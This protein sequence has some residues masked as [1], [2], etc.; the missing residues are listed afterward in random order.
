MRLPALLILL[1]L[2]VAGAFAATVM[3]RTP[4]GGRVA[5]TWPATSHGIPQGHVYTGVSGEPV[6]VNPYTTVEAAARGLVLAY[7][8]DTLLDRDP[9]TGALRPSLCERFELAADGG[10]CTFTLRDGVVFSDGTP[11]SM[12]DVMFGYEL[13]C[14]GHVEL[15]FP[16]Q[17][18]QRIGR[19]EVHDA[20]RFTV[21]FADRHFAALALVGEAWVVG[22]RAF[23]VAE[24]RRRLDVGESLPSVESP[25]FAELFDQIDS[26][27]G[28]GTG[29]YVLHND[30]DGE[31][32]WRRGSELVLVR[33][34]GSWH[35]KVR[36]GTWN[37]GGIR[38]S[39]QVAGASN[40]LLRHEVDWFGGSQLSALLAANP[41]LQQHYRLLRYAYPR[42]GAFRI[43]W[44]CRRGP[45]Q[46]A[47]VRRALAQ[48]VDRDQLVKVFD[49]AARPA[50]AH[51]N[52]GSPGCPELNHGPADPEAA[53][54]GLREAGF[55][56]ER[57][58]LH[59]KLVAVSGTPELRR[60][61]ELFAD[62][63]RRAGIELELH[64]VGPEQ[65]LE[66]KEAGDW[67]GL[68]ELRYF[69]SVGDPSVYLHSAG[70]CNWGGFVDARCDELCEAAQEESSAQ[71]R[72]ELWR[73]LHA[74]AHELQPVTLLVYPMVSLLLNRDIREMEPG[75]LGL[76]PY[77]AWVP[78]ELQRR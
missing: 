49:G 27:C 11:L 72:H 9:A 41:D 67:D 14:A 47:R 63:A 57:G 59:L 39:F 26:C 3:W 31:C 38:T 33:H 48:L 40:A 43:V 17:A 13:H 1:A 68:L 23:F 19:I 77:R 45:C 52:H 55:D 32:N 69:D 18:F 51:A 62:A 64:P 24:V 5:V 66:A 54:A 75:P 10:S 78:T 21:W 15:G 28:P 12:D 70:S 20:R 53:Q 60:M 8:H 35:R 25:R 16:A 58:A 36:E 34:E 74:R 61:R 50:L 30:P 71:R 7:T 76:S 29:P 44:N 46:D 6:D 37:L 22:Q 56:A 2:A 65:L 4:P 42:L 73:E